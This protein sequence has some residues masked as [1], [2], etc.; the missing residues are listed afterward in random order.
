MDKEKI[1]KLKSLAAL[2]N[3]KESELVAKA[4]FVEPGL[5]RLDDIDE[6]GYYFVVGV[7]LAKH[8][9]GAML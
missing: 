8:D 2:L 1:N 3:V 6:R 7:L 9:V 4:Q 5:A